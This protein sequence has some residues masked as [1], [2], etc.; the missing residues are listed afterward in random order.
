MNLED[1]PSIR[2]KLHKSPELSEQ[3]NQTSTKILSYLKECQ[4]S[5]LIANVGGHGILCVYDFHSPGPCIVF[6]AELDALPITEKGSQ[7]HKST[8]I[9]V[10]HACG[11]DGHMTILLGLAHY[12][13][14]K[15]DDIVG[16]I[17]LLFQPAEETAV[18]AKKIM[19]DNRFHNLHPTHIFGLHNLP[20]YPLGTVLYKNSVFASASQ[21]LILRF[22]GISSHAGHPEQG[23]SPLLVM[24][25]CIKLLQKISKKYADKNND[26]FITIIHMKLG[27]RAFG[28]FPG[29]GSI[30]AT[31]R[32]FSQKR[33][34]EMTDETLNAIN[35]LTNTFD[36]SWDHEWVEIFPSLVN[37]QDCT[38]ILKKSVEA[39]NGSM[40]EIKKPFRWSED[41]SYYLQQYPGA[42]FGLGAGMNHH[43]LH[44]PSY[45]FPDE[46]IEYG[47]KI[48][49]EI[50]RFT[51]E[52][53]E[54]DSS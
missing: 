54:S 31:F 20:Q 9:G 8:H 6:R 36:G 10:S 11:H 2:K 45:D 42:F 53:Y 39:I 13:S 3:E 41:F 49:K 5:E 51:N 26:T 30:M 1:L 32:S 34:D 19:Q 4:P 25:D 7:N 44:H 23:L 16:K 28:T 40:I 38:K 35:N 27:E 21:G 47:I 17:I 48:F 46:L 18:G 22:H 33:M 12:L 29:E 24:L 14:Q 43:V 52:K 15:P 50:I 37:N